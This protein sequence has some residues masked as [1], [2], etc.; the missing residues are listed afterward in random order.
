MPNGRQ[1][2]SERIYVSGKAL[3]AGFASVAHDMPAAN[4]NTVQ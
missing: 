2:D 1:G 3:A 4:A